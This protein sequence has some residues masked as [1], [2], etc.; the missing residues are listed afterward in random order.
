MKEINLT[1]WG[2]TNDLVVTTNSKKSA[3]AIVGISNNTEG[4]NNVFKL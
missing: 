1:P 4:L 2:L 3:E